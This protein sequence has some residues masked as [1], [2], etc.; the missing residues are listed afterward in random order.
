MRGVRGMCAS[1]RTSAAARGGLRI[2]APFPENKLCIHSPQAI[3]PQH[4]SC[5]LIGVPTRY[6][7]GTEGY[8]PFFVQ[9]I[10][11]LDDIFAINLQVPTFNPPLLGHRHMDPRI[12][13]SRKHLRHP[14]DYIL[15]AQSQEACHVPCCKLCDRQGACLGECQAVILCL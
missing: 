4:G 2:G 6:T 10:H 11:D 13:L 5:R 14:L 15:R 9:L 7:Q 12:V 1:M 3:T 8:V